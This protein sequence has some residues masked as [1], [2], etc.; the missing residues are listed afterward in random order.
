MA[1]L[2]NTSVVYLFNSSGRRLVTTRGVTVT[3]GATCVDVAMTN[4]GAIQAILYTN[5]LWMS[6]DSGTTYNK[7]TGLQ[8]DT[9][10]KLRMN[11]EYVVVL[12]VN[13]AYYNQNVTSNYSNPFI[14]FN[15][16]GLNTDNMLTCAI[17]SGSSQFIYNVHRTGLYVTMTAYNDY[18]QR[19]SLSGFTFLNAAIATN[20]DGYRVLL[21]A[22]C[23][24][25]LTRVWKT[26]DGGFL[27]FGPDSMLSYNTPLLSN[28]YISASISINGTNQAFVA[29]TKLY[30]SNNTGSS[31]VALPG[32]FT[33]A[34]VH[35]SLSYAIPTYA[36]TK[37][38]VDRI[39]LAN[40]NV[41]TLMTNVGTTV[42]IGGTLNTSSVISLGTNAGKKN[43]GTYAIAI[44]E[45]AGF[46]FQGSSAVAIGNQA[47]SVYQG[48]E[49]AAFGFNAGG[50]YQE[51]YA[52][53]I[54]SN[55]GYYV[56]RRNSVAIGSESGYYIQGESSVAIGYQ[57]GQYSQGSYSIAIGYQAG[58]TSQSSST[59]VL[60]ASGVT[61]NGSTNSAFYVAPVRNVTQT[62]V[63]G[64][65]TSTK[66]I[67]YWA[68]TFVIQHPDEDDKYLV[69]A[70]LEG[71]EAGV[72][73]RGEGVIAE[74]E[75]KV[76]ITLPAYVKNLA[77]DLTVH[78]TPVIDDEDVDDETLPII[79]SSRIRDN[80]FTV[81]ANKALGFHWMVF[82]KRG[83]VNTEV[84]KSDTVMRGDGP[85]K[86]LDPR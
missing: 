81:Y 21:V 16:G 82:G 43:Q 62:N 34:Y 4:N 70:C 72:Y 60:N 33:G 71:P 53:A 7:V 5:A 74:G 12:G 83:D 46:N 77:K 15:S 66:E 86:W 57:A 37:A 17:S 47:G 84:N 38:Y 61:L 52:T 10:T 24:D 64:Y 40:I 18:I 51:S 32:A 54:G 42:R 55:A 22:M 35:P 69:H 39:D 49:A 48:A 63:L 59:I 67:S 36:S 8:T 11:S 76:T 80:K 73:Y 75:K 9:Y 23:S 28:G 85:Y 2:K 58:Q 56:Q 29:N 41:M 27:G 31:F 79:F 19:V 30:V 1:G 6:S 45:K 20:Q 26:S 50:N 44:G 25:G 13:T 65:N 68:K 78:L 14:K 3:N